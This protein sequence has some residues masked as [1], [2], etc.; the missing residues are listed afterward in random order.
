[1]GFLTSLRTTA[2]FQVFWQL[3]R[4]LK[5]N[6]F[7]SCPTS[8]WI[9]WNYSPLRDFFKK[10]CFA[11]SQKTFTRVLVRATI[12]VDLREVLVSRYRWS[13][14]PLCPYSWWGGSFIVLPPFWGQRNVAAG[15]WMTLIHSIDE[16]WSLWPCTDSWIAQISTLKSSSS[17]PPTSSGQCFHLVIEFKWIL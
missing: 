2:S 11:F 8:V 16:K 12:R 9:V 1:M 3:F 4:T 7:C 6:Y 5:K 13:L 17:I 15:N 14:T 10:R